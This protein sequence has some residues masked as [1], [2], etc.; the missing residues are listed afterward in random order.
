MIPTNKFEPKHLRN[1]GTS[2]LG[3]TIRV[4]YI[5]RGNPLKTYKK[6]KT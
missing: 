2:L 6:R 3:T 1:Q 4:P 5:T